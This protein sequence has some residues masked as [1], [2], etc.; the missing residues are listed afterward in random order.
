MIYSSTSYRTICTFNSFLPFRTRDFRQ[1]QLI[2]RRELTIIR[3]MSS[4]LTPFAPLII[5]IFNI[6][7]I[8]VNYSTT[9]TIIF[10]VFL[11]IIAQ[12]C[13]ECEIYWFRTPALFHLV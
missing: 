3:I 12:V 11:A 10:L 1:F 9:K 4:F 6:V 8:P 5:S 13:C 2:T 7:P